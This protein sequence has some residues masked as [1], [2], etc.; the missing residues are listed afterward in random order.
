MSEDDVKKDEAITQATDALGGKGTLYGVAQ[1]GRSN[2]IAIFSQ[3][4]KGKTQ[5]VFRQVLYG[6][7]DAE[8]TFTKKG[9]NASTDEWRRIIRALRDSLALDLRGS[10]YIELLKLP[11]EGTNN[12]I[13]V[14]SH[15]FRD[16]VRIVIG[17]VFNYREYA[18]KGSG[19]SFSQHELAGVIDSL[20]KMVDD[21]GHASEA[22]SSDSLEI[23]SN[24]SA[25]EVDYDR[26]HKDLFG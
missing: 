18:G 17:K 12:A 13:Q 6:D 2:C 14:Y 11:I 25:N 16:E 3:Q 20:E 23:K 10:S 5:G 15:I 7:Q 8:P 1:I 26:L 9:L 24:Y 22:T 19:A 4:Y 21:L